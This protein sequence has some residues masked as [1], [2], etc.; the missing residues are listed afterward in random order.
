MEDDMKAK[1]KYL[2]SENEVK[3]LKAGLK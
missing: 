1:E 3:K 2:L